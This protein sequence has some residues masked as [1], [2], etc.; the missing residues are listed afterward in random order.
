MSARPFARSDAPGHRLHPDGWPSD[1]AMALVRA[2]LSLRRTA[3]AMGVGFVLLALLLVRLPWQQS[4]L[5]TGRVIAYAP[6]D[7]AQQVEA[8]VYG[9]VERWLVSEGDHVEAGDP[10]A[11]LRDNDE[12]LLSRLDEQRGT[13]DNEQQA[14][15]AQ[16][17][18]YEEKV[19]AARAARDR[20]VAEAAD[21]VASLERKRV[22]ESAEVEVEQRQL[23]RIEALAVDGLASPRSLDLARLKRDKAVATLGALDR[24]ISAATAYA[25]KA[26]AEAE[27]KIAEAE[28]DLQAARAKMS[29]LRRKQIDL[30]TKLSRQKAQLLLAPRAGRVLRLY[31]GPGAGQVKPGDAVATLVPDTDRR[32]VEVWIDGN[33]VPL[34]QDGA[35]V[36]VVFE[37]W[38]AL[39][40]V[41]LPGTTN[42]NGT[43]GGRVAFLDAT[44]DGKGKFRVVV[45][46]DE[47]AGPWP[48]ASLLRQGV[49]AKAWVLLGTVPS[50][51]E[52]WRRI[53]GF[54]PLPTVEKGDAT[55]LPSNKK[56]RAPTELK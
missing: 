31:G 11:A 14:L 40:F 22:G 35:E 42:N 10:I 26:R 53:N 15:T 16:L 18:S 7:R 23:E 39:Q 44:D 13:T 41:G 33:D 21:K 6:E 5:G 17:T 49:R 24:E 51:Y 52:V 46:P 20:V 28:A 27:S 43:F 4:A 3:T 55:P 48:D 2:P 1:P 19:R 30:D 38:P 37:G 12:A 25:G 50:G 32:A 8:P 54:P 45:V 56:P 36:R 34:V 47:D 29:D 9:V